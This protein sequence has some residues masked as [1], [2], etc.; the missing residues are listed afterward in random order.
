MLRKSKDIKEARLAA[1]DGEIGHAK[2]FYFED[3]TWTI[4]NLVADAGNW[5]PNRQVLLSPFV[6]R[7]RMLILTAKP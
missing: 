4:R 3:E 6:N 7:G 5:L 2:D 1:L